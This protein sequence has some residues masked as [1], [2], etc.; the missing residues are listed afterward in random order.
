M[1]SHTLG[2]HI[3]VKLEFKIYQIVCILCCKAENWIWYSRCGLKCWTEGLIAPL[4]QLT[5]LLL[6]QNSIN[7]PSSPQGHTAD[8]RLLWC[9]PGPLGPLLKSCFV[10][11]QP[12]PEWMGFSCSM[13]R[14]SRFPSFHFSS[15]LRSLQ[16][17][18]LSFGISA[19]I[20]ANLLKV[21]SILLSRS[22][23]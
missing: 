18:V 4:N 2:T 10:A 8:T 17:A 7:W 19:V 9:P 16:I 14:T 23:L 22:L 5:I 12:Q 13:C 15:L 11:S 21:H 20:S 6:I 1:S 3:S